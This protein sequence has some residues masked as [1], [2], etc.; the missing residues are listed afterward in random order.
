[1]YAH[2]E[3]AP[4]QPQTWIAKARLPF[5]MAE[6]AGLEAVFIRAADTTALGHRSKRRDASYVHRTPDGLTPR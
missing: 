2:K 6:K 4:G 3:P 1:M 5:A